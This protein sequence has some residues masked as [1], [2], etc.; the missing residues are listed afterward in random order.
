MPISATGISTNRPA[1]AGGFT[2]VEILVVVV[3]IGVLAAGALLS[4]G[5]LGRDRQL[6]TERDR[7][8]GLLTLVREQAGMQNREY[9]LRGFQQGYEF[10][11]YEPRA[12]RWERVSDDRGLRRRRLP[13]GLVLTL[14]VE[15]R[16]VVLPKVDAKDAIP[17][18]MLFSSGELNVFEITVMREASPDGFRILPSANEDSI[19][20]VP[21]AAGAR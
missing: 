16:P 13:E 18:V 2:L 6:E 12:E 11:V 21:I 19:E 10:M 8:V 4:L 14:R 5:V 20:V 3:I 15:G 7:L 1:D 9:G 17:Q